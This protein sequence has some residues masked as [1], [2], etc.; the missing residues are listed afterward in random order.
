MKV[1]KIGAVWCS[2]CLVMRPRWEEVESE[3]S[4]LQTEYYDFDESENIAKKYNLTEGKLPVFIF[5]DKKG[6]EIDRKQG[7][8]SKEQIKKLILKYKDK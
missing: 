8:F 1:L 3:N 6:K 2:S 5:L 4:W 7:E